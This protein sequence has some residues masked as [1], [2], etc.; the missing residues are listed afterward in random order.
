MIIGVTGHRPNKL[1]GYGPEAT[2]LLDTL[3]NG[4]LKHLKA[5]NRV[6]RVLTGM[7]LGFDQAIARSCILNDIEFDAVVPFLGQELSWPEESQ[8]TYKWIISQARIRKVVS[9]C[10]YSSWKMHVRNQW[11]VDNCD[12]LYALYDGTH[13]G[14]A[15][16]VKYAHEKK[17]KIVNLWPIWRQLITE[18]AQ[19]KIEWSDLDRV[20][21]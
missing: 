1:G 17:R 21:I 10:G 19:T 20:V 11:I 2:E 6:S 16:C 14:T 15:N 4:L 18:G 7:A 9:L 13:G 3:C 8:D 5:K 12:T